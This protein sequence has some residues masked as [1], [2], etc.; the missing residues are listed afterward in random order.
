MKPPIRRYCPECQRVLYDRS[1]ERCGFC[2]APIP[3][4][5]RFSEEE[6]AEIDRMADEIEL[7]QK[8]REAITR[9]TPLGGDSTATPFIPPAG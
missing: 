5:L 8:I 4:E 1:L 2:D 9:A 7:N 6:K 3:E